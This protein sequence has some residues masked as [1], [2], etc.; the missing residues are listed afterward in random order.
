[1]WLDRTVATA[2]VRRVLTQMD[3]GLDIEIMIVQIS[4]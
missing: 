3:A 4:I 2:A 1:V